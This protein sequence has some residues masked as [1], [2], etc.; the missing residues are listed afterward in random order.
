MNYD[1]Q[2][3]VWR[4]RYYEL[5]RTLEQVIRQVGK[6][7]NSS[8]EGRHAEFGLRKV[9]THEFVG[10]A[11]II[12]VA[13]G[14]NLEY[15]FDFMRDGEVVESINF[16]RSNSVPVA[17]GQRLGANECSVSVKTNAPG[18]RGQIQTKRVAI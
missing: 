10:T 7:M 5:E 9:V 12:C 6:S 11:Q 4:D 8:R 17:L 16:Q 2:E 3:I 1:E 14:E 13:N 18:F 15:A